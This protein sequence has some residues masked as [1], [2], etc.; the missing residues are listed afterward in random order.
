MAQQTRLLHNS[1]DKLGVDEIDILEI[2]PSVGGGFECRHVEAQLSINPV[3]YISRVP[4]ALQKEEGIG[5]NSAKKRSI[6]DLQ[7]GVA[8]WVEKKFNKKEKTALK[9]QLCPGEWSKELVINV[10]K[11][12]EE[13]ALLK[14][15]GVVVHSLRDFLQEMAKEEGPIHAA[16]GADLVSLV[17]LK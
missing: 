5:A 16:S 14:A 4:K 6:V 1:W 3:S 13:V 17:S 15:A 10:V 11:L 8:E 7:Q 2:R 9:A 12:P